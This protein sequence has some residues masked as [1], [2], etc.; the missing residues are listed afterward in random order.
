MAIIL[1]DHVW[2]A[3]SIKSGSEEGASIAAGQSL[4]IETSPDGEEILNVQCPVGKSW[5]AR[6]IVEITETNA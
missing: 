3:K 4:R 1:T 2:T 6:I 5:T